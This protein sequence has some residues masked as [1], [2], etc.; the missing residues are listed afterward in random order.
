MTRTPAQR[1]VRNQR[2]RRPQ[3]TTTSDDSDRYRAIG[4][5]ALIG[6]CHCAALVSSTGSIDWCCMPR[7]DSGSVF[8]R[9]LDHDRGGSYQLAPTDPDATTTR[10]YID[11]TLVLVTTFETRHGQADVYDCFTMTKGGATRPHR[12]LLRIVEGTR[13]TVMFRMNLTARFD[14]GDLPP[15]LRHHGNNLYTAVGGNDALLISS[16][17][18][19]AAVS[20]HDLQATFE[21]HA[22]TRVRTSVSW[23]PPE[24][25]DRLPPTPSPS[26]LDQRLAQ[27]ITW[28]QRWAAKAPRGYG[29]SPVRRSAIILKALTYAPTGA[30]VAAATTSLP[31]AIG[32]ERNWDYRYSWIRDSQ[33]T[34]RSLAQAGHPAEADGFR[35]F[36]ERSAAGHAA[37][38]QIM[39]GAGGERR[40]PEITLPQLAGYRDSQPVRVGNCAA[41]QLQLDVYGYLL[42]LA[43]RWHQRGHSPDDDYWRFLLSLVDAAAERW[44]QPDCGI[45]ELRGAP[46]HFVHSKVM[47]WATLDRGI[48]LAEAC[49]RQAPARRWKRTRDSIREAVETDGYD[50]QRGVFRRAFASQELDAALL[51]IPTFDF[52]AYDDERMIRTTDAI[53][54]DLNDRGFVR[55]YAGDDG[56]DGREGTFVA[57][58]FWL[59]EALA[60]QGQLT[61]AQ[62]VFEHAEAT[63]ND[64]GIFTE[65]FDTS[66][67]QPVGNAPQGLSHLSHI[68]AAL[69]IAS[70]QH[71]HVQDMTR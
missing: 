4:D 19:L 14:Y 42:D 60:R 51:L 62:Q 38:L 49:L 36:V 16:D 57:C 55:R 63:A 47:C 7:F 61:D 25:L 46:E 48:R 29:D 18:D 15:W 67:R 50:N 27:T 30:V 71:P 54:H 41:E 6:D 1:R 45:W 65:E 21:V 53:R 5:Y 10:R 12:Q 9:I 44:D 3:P 33:F 22:G 24:T 34:V 35:R 31:E 68:A 70:Q 2:H 59:A 66:T 39:Y 69:T 37:S 13:G 43:W 28:W 17:T 23:H 8:G 58:T 40:L 26:D 20:D 56:L 64:V 11:D 52:V 32:H